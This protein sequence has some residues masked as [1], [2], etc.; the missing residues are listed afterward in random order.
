MAFFLKGILLGMIVCTAP[1]PILTIIFKEGLKRGFRFALRFGMGVAVV[2]VFYCLLAFIGVTP[3]LSTFPAFIPAMWLIGGSIF[4]AIGVIDLV[5]IIRS[6]GVIV[7]PKKYRDLD[8]SHP[9]KRGLLISLFNPG[10]VL[11]WISVSGAFVHFQGES[12]LQFIAGVALGSPLFFF[13]L[14]HLISRL[15]EKMTEK[16][17]YFCTLIAGVILIVVGLY[18]FYRFSTLL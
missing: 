17:I 12:S 4:L 3:L 11:F 16:F 6:R 1:G 5:K 9:F 18:F 15:R 2:D 7:E 10:A 13:L 14:A 8:Y